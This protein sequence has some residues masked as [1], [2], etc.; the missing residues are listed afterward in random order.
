ML[1]KIKRLERLD[2]FRLRI[3]F[4]DGSSGV[5]DFA[6]V[7]NEPGPM[8]EPLRDQSYFSRVFLEFGAPTWPNGF[9]IAPEWLRREMEKAGELSRE[10]AE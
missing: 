4:S 10:A 2:G 8:V 6:S 5:H 3:V 9:D 1:T 7:V